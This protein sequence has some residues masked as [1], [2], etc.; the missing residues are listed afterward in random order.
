MKDQGNISLIGTHEKHHEDLK[1]SGV[2]Q[3][4][5]QLGQLNLEFGM[6]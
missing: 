2:K 6:D 1:D 5:N 3:D 4:N